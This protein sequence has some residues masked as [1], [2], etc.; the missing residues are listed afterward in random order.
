[1]FRHLTLVLALMFA[2][3]AF[4]DH[5]EVDWALAYKVPEA[6]CKKPNSRRSN[7]VAGRADRYERKLKRYIR[8][9]KEYQTVLISDH[10][11]I[12]KAAEHGINQEQ[13]L[14][15]VDNLKQI[16]GTLESLGEQF[17]I[18]QDYTE[19]QRIFVMGNRPSI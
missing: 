18:E 17:V 8:C 11:R 10:Q 3:S 2:N 4:A 15:F 5:P 7:E 12:F 13:A 1:M 14:V 16:E 9:V 6:E 19:L